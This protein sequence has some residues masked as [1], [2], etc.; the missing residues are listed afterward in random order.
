MIYGQ[1]LLLVH[2]NIF[3]LLYNNEIN[4]YFSFAQII[5]PTEYDPTIFYDLF[6]GHTKEFEY[7][8]DNNWLLLD[9]HF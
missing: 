3:R 6:T 7:T 4:V 5:F 8:W 9:V 2:F 1:N